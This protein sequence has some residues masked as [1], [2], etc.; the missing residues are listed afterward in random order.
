MD[1]K[2]MRYFILI[3]KSYEL[4]CCRTCFRGL[5]PGAAEELCCHFG[6]QRKPCFISGAL[7]ALWTA[8]CDRD[9]SLARKVAM[10]VT[11]TSDVFG[12]KPASTDVLVLMASCVWCSARAVMRNLSL[13]HHSA[14][15]NWR[16]NMLIET[17]GKTEKAST[18]PE[19]CYLLQMLLSL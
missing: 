7:R 16:L 11:R 5:A 14:L 15:P 18:F 8:K 13:V 10:S 1:F 2:L 12:T 17:Q 9:L 6:S 19:Y 4:T 3:F